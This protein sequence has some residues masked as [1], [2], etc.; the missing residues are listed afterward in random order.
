MEMVKQELLNNNN[1]SSSLIIPESTTDT[2]TLAYATFLHRE[3]GSDIILYIFAPLFPVES[4]VGILRNQLFYVTVI[5]LLLAC[6]FSFYLSNRISRL[7]RSITN[8]AKELSKGNYRIKFQEVQYSVIIA[9]ADTLTYNSL[10]VEK[11]YLF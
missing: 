6:I 5:S 4:T 1:L 9:L 11:N 7:I 10:E 8:L 3:N 2:N